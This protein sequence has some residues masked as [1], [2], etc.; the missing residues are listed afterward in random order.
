MFK[1]FKAMKSYIQPYKKLY[2]SSALMT[3]V[4][5][6][7][8]IVDPYLVGQIID[9]VL[10]DQDTTFVIMG[11]LIIMGVTIFRTMLRYGYFVTFEKFSQKVVYDLRKDLY[12]KLQSLDFSYFDKTP[13]GQIMSK[14]TGDIEAIRHF[15]AWITHVTIFHSVVFIIAIIAMFMINPVLASTLIL[16]VPFITFF[17]IR[18]SKSVKPI[19]A[20]IREQFS[21]LNTVVQENISGNKLV[22][23]LAREP[24]EI[25]KFQKENEAYK[26]KNMDAAKVWEDNLPALDAFAVLFNVV[27]L[28][29]GSIL[30]LKGKMTIGELVAFNRLL[31][32]IN[33]PLRMLGWMIN[34][35]QN[36]VASFDRVKEL[37][38]E[39]SDLIEHKE[40]IA[41]THLKGYVRFEKVSFHYEDLPVLE[42]VSFEVNPGQTVGLLGSTGSGKSTLISLISR[43]YEATS[44]QILIDG[45]PIES[46]DIYTLRNNI[47]IAMQ[48]IFLFSD[49][50][51]GNIAYGVPDASRIKV[52]LAAEIAGVNEFI[53]QFD[54]N[55][56]TIVG[57]RGVGLS[58][59][60]RQRIAL[61]RAIIEDPAIL[62]LDDTT[63][64]VDMETEYKILTELKKINE[65][66]TTFIIAHRISSVKDADIILVMDEGRIIERGTHTSLLEEQGY[67]YDVF[68]Q[69]M[70]EF[71][72]E[73][74]EGA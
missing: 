18:L 44:G 42:D 3:L 30:I 74:R 10:T 1:T 34:G 66:R 70:G 28:F 40:S 7:L 57:E 24:Y 58:G 59:G 68:T 27:V 54:D 71:D 38:D 4:F 48:D 39:K 49:T 60:Q 56:D 62:I 26:E 29:V 31:W 45:E 50:I 21:K 52:R 51:E 11:S 33:N 46:Y 25:E 61:A 17:S 72:V 73:T 14:M 47:S 8:A 69:Q 63:S 43:F 41:H 55:Y 35:T 2:I 65:N 53:H 15:F 23:A 16:I 12:V 36:F 22:K 19:F 20:E 67:Y 32:M 5:A 9:H 64:A 13:N 37:L 6:L